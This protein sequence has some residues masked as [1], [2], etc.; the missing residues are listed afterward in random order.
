MV[1]SLDNA[2]SFTSTIASVAVAREKDNQVERPYRK[3][4]RCDESH[5]VAHL[6]GPKTRTCLKILGP[7]PRSR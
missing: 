6:T 5:A 4:S 7:M 3:Y 1:I 2:L